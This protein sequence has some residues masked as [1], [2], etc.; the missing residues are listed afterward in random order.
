M[1]RGVPTSGGADC[2]QAVQVQRVL[3]RA[4]GA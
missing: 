4:D 2:R 3:D 1:Q